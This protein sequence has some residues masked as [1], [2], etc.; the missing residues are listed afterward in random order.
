MKRATACGGVGVGAGAMRL[1][2]HRDKLLFLSQMLPDNRISLSGGLDRRHQFITC[3]FREP[4]P[5]P[6]VRVY[7]FQ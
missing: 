3:I 2:G 7:S 1:E 5:P 6:I 4:I